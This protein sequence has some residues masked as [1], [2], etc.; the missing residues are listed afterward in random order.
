M[1]FIYSLKSIS[2]KSI[3]IRSILSLLIIISFHNLQAQT[4]EILNVD[5]SKYPKMKAEISVKD[6]TNKEIRTFSNGDFKITDGGKVRPSGTIFCTPN[7]KKFS[8]IITIDKTASMQFNAKDL[9]GTNTTPPL[10]RDIAIN[11]AKTLIDVLPLD[12]S[13]CALTEFSAGPAA[14]SQRMFFSQDRDSLKSEVGKIAFGGGTDINSGFL[15]KN[16]GRGALDVAVFARWKP[17]IVFI[18]DGLHDP[19]FTTPK[20]QALKSGE[21][22]DRAR[23]INASVFMVGLGVDLSGEMQ[24]IATETGG[25][26]YNNLSEQAQLQSALSQILS[27]ANLD[28]S[29]AP[30]EL[31]WTTDCSGGNLEIEYTKLNNPKGTFNY[32]LIPETLPILVANPVNPN[33]ILNVPIGGSQ[34]IDVEIKATQND[35]LVT[36]DVSSKDVFK[37]T[38]WG[39]TNPP[40]TLKKD[41]TRKI[42]IEYKPK[43]INCIEDE[44]TFESDACTI[45]KF[46]MKGGTIII[47]DINVGFATKNVPKTGIFTQKFCNNSCADIEITGFEINGAD[48]SEFKINT[49][50]K[51]VKSG[52]CLDIDVTYTPSEVRA[53]NATYTI[54]TRNN[55]TFTANLVGTG[56][57]LAEIQANDVT[58]EAIKC[59]DL[60]KIVTITNNGA[61]PLNITSIT[62]TNTVD[63]TIVSGGNITTLAPGSSEN[64]TVK[65][66]P[67][68]AGPNYN[69]DLV[70]INDS[71]NDKNKVVK[72]TASKYVIDFTTDIATEIDFGI[73]CPGETVTR[74]VEISNLSNTDLVL[75]GSTVNGTGY[76][77]SASNWNITQSGKENVTISFTA[78]ND[79]NY[80]GTWTILDDCNTKVLNYPLKARVIAPILNGPSTSFTAN[81]GTFEEKTVRITN[82]TDRDLLFDAVSDN[83]QYTIV[84]PNPATAISVQAK[85]FVDLTVRFT[86][87][88]GGQPNGLINLTANACNYTNT[89]SLIG[90]PKFATAKIVIDT[91]HAGLIGDVITIPVKLEDKFQVSTSA[92]KSIQIG[93]ELDAN[94]LIPNGS[95]PIGTITGDK[96]RIV[97]DLNLDGT[98]NP[99]SYPLTFTIAESNVDFTNIEFYTQPIVDNDAIAI[100]T[101]NGRFTII[102]AK[103]E[104]KIFTKSAK[105]GDVIDFPIYIRD[106]GTYLR[107]FHKGVKTYLRFNASVLEPVGLN[108]SIVVGNQNIREIEI[109]QLMNFSEVRNNNNP[110]LNPETGDILLTTVKFRAMLG[111]EVD[112]KIYILNSN[113]IEGKVEITPDSTNFVLLGVCTDLDGTV[114]LINP[115][116]PTPGV[117][118]SPN[119]VSENLKVDIIAIEQ[120][121]HTVKIYDL[122]GNLK[123]ELLSKEI[124]AGEYSF[125]LEKSNLEVGTYMVVFNTPTQTFTQ[126]L[127]FVK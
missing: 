120:G 28:G 34:V 90:D 114:R 22:I 37:V 7:V 125:N 19:D 88:Q 36:K 51:T 23:A 82:P 26:V 15:G 97:M 95:T 40:F 94:I 12:R 31:E 100:T 49:A 98:N 118:V 119:P 16:G 112:S 108:S 50:P 24:A 104:A 117:F 69:T 113:T 3:S 53:S 123:A 76:S 41:E 92:S 2:F 81:A 70:I 78:N 87:V 91:T 57:G 10:K 21:I 83:P 67:K 27:L 79:G 71:D 109:T 5:A 33:T 62:L 35:V 54:R 9:N 60:D 18:T 85:S 110:F 74:T 126:R 89:V 17:I 46:N 105:P 96:R 86:P 44:L 61:I 25:K 106:K 102:P 121:L 11:S 101:Q 4:L 30:C 6:N 45:G 32:N 127:N 58:F 63:F 29:L 115:F 14:T 75:T 68:G 38:N 80:N 124:N 52:E 66:E 107:N 8:M 122:V 42:K 56:S 13:E 65:F 72:L 48:K 84:N 20:G 59:G 64:V 93:L 77:T 99:Q 73:V 47:E 103:V 116:G 43:D 55:N 39:G 111:N 1:K